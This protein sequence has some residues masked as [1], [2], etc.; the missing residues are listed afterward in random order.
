M[1]SLGFEERTTVKHLQ[2]NLK[3]QCTATYYL[4]LKRNFKLGNSSAMD[5]CSDNFR[6][7][8]LTPVFTLKQPRYKSFDQPRPSRNS[9]TLLKNSGTHHKNSGAPLENSGTFLENSRKLFESEKKLF[10]SENLE[11]ELR[12]SIKNVNSQLKCVYRSTEKLKENHSP[13]R[14]HSMKSVDSKNWGEGRKDWEEGRKGCEEESMGKG[15]VDWEKGN[16]I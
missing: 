7:E 1:K 4:L 6:T 13:S 10:E 5:I 14:K 2:N 16:K 15:S 11:K 8:L 3:D 9:R 12:K